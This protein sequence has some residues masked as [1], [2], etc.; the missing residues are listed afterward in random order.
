RTGRF[1]GEKV[2]GVRARTLEASA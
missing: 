2:F 1:G